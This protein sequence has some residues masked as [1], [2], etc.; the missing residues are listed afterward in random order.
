MIPE[1][2]RISGI[3]RRICHEEPDLALDYFVQGAC[4]LI[5]QGRFSEP[6]SSLTTEREWLIGTDP[7]LAWLEED[8]I[9]DAK[10]EPILV[11]EAHRAFSTWAID[12]G[13]ASESLPPARTFSQRVQ[14][15]DPLISGWRTSGKRY[16][17]GLRM[18]PTA[19]TSTRAKFSRRWSA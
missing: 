5:R 19:Q 6:Q 7:V 3:G 1:H 11:R 13:F 17:T 8:V 15:A 2:E 14:A 12:E 18:H 10:A 16:L 9:V 4:R